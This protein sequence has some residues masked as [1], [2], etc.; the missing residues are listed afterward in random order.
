MSSYNLLKGHDIRLKGNPKKDIIDI[1][2]SS[3]IAI[4]PFQYK[5]MKPKL[6]VKKGDS[7]K[8]GS[9]IF[10]DKTKESVKVVSSASGIVEDIVLGKRRI[11]EKVVIKVEG[12]QSESLSV[13]KSEDFKDFLLNN[14]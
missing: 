5:G 7:V 13:D 14:K 2:L 6:L 10:Y 11:V 8:V 3:H 4:H 12:D 1:P 9:P